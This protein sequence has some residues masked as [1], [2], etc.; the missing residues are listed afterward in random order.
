M[1]R[2]TAAML[3]PGAAL[4]AFAADASH[5]TDKMAVG[6]HESPGD[7]Q[8]KRVL[9]SGTPLEILDRAARLCKVQLGDGDSGWLE[10][11]YITDE[12]PAR[13][14]LVEAQARTSQLR[15]QVNALTRQLETSRQSK[16]TLERRLQ[17]AEHL[18][19]GQASRR[20]MPAM[21]SEALE[22]KVAWTVH[23]AADTPAPREGGTSQWLAA[24]QGAAAGF[25]VTAL[26]FY[27]RCRKK[28]GSLRI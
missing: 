12:K 19:T 18:L 7:K 21:G 20:D 16:E 17:A 3:L 9:T 10:C 4:L 14:M 22:S 11:R 28:Y 23:G 15:D 1:R 8:P 2:R 25:A 24:G 5:I 27:W 26:A 6:M 13:A